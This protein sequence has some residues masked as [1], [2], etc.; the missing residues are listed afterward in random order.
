MNLRRSIKPLG[1]PFDATALVNVVLL[2]L[3]FFLLS[4]TFVIQP[5][6]KVSPPVGISGG[7]VRDSRYI[8]NVTA[9][10]PPLI[11]F[12]NQLIAMDKLEAELKEIAA[13]QPNASVVLRADENVSHGVVTEIMNHAFK[14]GV[15]PLIATQAP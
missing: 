5:G 9:Q 11:F 4:S 15:Q 2:L 12:N 14:A 3:V 1:G 7:G 10:N 8:I 6:I 13:K